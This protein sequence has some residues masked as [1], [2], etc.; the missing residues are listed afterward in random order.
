MSCCV[1]SCA[2]R[3]LLI[4]HMMGDKGN[5]SAVYEEVLPN[6]FFCVSILSCE[7][8]SFPIYFQTLVTAGGIFGR[9]NRSNQ[10]VFDAISASCRAHFR[11]MAPSMGQARSTKISCRNI[12]SLRA[13]Y[14]FIVADPF[15]SCPTLKLIV[16]RRVLLR[17]LCTLIFESSIVYV[18][19]G[20]YF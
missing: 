20:V 5:G 6:S 9:L 18:C 8:L 13:T 14:F 15:S 1:L 12:S 19:T 4:S 11:T 16:C 17:D 3:Y 2:Y 7:I 10:T